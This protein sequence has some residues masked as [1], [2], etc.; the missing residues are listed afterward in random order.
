M[1][2]SQLDLNLLIILKQLLIEKHVTNTALTLNISQPSVSRSLHKLRS[3]FDDPLLVRTSSGYELT[4]KAAFIQ[5][6]LNQ[7]LGH[8]ERLIDG[9]QF[10]PNV[11]EKTIKLYGLPPQVEWLSALLVKRFQQDAPHMILDIDTVPKPHFQGLL[12]GD[13]HFVVS[14]LQPNSAEHDLHRLLLY[15]QDFRLILSQNHP[16]AKEALTPQNLSQCQFGQLSLQ[17]DKHLTIETRFHE[18]DILPEGRKIASPIKLNSFSSAAAIAESTDIIFHLPTF[19]ANALCEK[20]HLVAR[21]VPYELQCHDRVETYLYWHKRHHKDPM[22]V[23]A[24]NLIKEITLAH[25]AQ[26]KTLF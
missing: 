13:V 18:L 22:H 26:T 14:P 24:R 5:Q 4:P 23:W 15:R 3:L 10:D 11:S 2:L 19:Y 1:N 6:E 25:I 21:E 7:V 8:L 16:L 9:Q 12:N 17:G 20:H